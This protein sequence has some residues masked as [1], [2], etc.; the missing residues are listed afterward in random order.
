[1]ILDF[2]IVTELTLIFICSVSF[3]FLRQHKNRLKRRLEYLKNLD[4]ELK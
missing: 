1:M 2:I 3:Y 4:K